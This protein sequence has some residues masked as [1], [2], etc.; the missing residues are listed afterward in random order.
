MNPSYGLAVKK[1]RTA[2]YLSFLLCGISIST[3]APMVPLAKQRT[4]LNEA[5]LGLV[6]LLMGAGAIITMPFVGRIMQKTGS[7]SVILISSLVST[8]ALP[9]LTIVDTPLLLGITLFIFGAGIGTLDVSMNAQA[10]VVQEKINRPVM[11]S[12]HG[13]FSFGGLIGAMV[14]GLLVLMKLTPFVSAS[15]ISLLLVIT[16]IVHYKNFLDHQQKDE[17]V[18]FSFRLPKGPVIMLGIFCFIFFLMEGA[19]LDWGA[20]FLRDHRGFGISM[21]GAGYA[22]FSVSMA[23]MRFTGDKLVHKY[24]NKK[25]VFWGSTVAATGL[26]IAVFLPWQAAAIAGFLLIG[27]GAAN[28]VPIFFSSAGKADKSSPEIAIAAVTT[29]GYTGQLAGPAMIGFVAEI[30]SLPIALGLM[31]VPLL[32]VALIYNLRN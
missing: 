7:R 10:V 22:V 20:L 2:S 32:L 23:V 4:G 3:W 19:L 25:L 18:P 31:I 27:I 21:A 8:L 1:A 14:F 5:G 28:V 16:A 11:S 15:I 29:M 6:L 26:A 24:G 9:A 30:T 13:M 12:F 17:S